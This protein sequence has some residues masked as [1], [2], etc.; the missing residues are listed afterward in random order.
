MELLY[1]RV[2]SLSRQKRLRCSDNDENKWAR[3]EEVDCKE[4]EDAS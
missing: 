4:G 3:E 1:N 2:C